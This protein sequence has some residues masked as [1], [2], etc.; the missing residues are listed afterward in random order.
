V[1]DHA[2]SETDDLFVRHG[3]SQAGGNDN[4]KLVAT[5]T[6]TG[7]NGNPK[8][9]ATTIHEPFTTA[10]PNRGLLTGIDPIPL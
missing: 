3:N 10:S 4:P 6:Q 7:G 8:L 5:A 2:Q 1:I 9:V